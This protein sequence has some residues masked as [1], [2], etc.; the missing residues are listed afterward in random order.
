[1]CLILLEVFITTRY[2]KKDD[3]EERQQQ[4]RATLMDTQR[5]Q[6]ELESFVDIKRRNNEPIH[7]E[8]IKHYQQLVARAF[9]SQGNWRRIYWVEGTA[10]IP[11]GPC[12]TFALS[13]GRVFRNKVKIKRFNFEIIVDVK[14]L[15]QLLYDQFPIIFP[16]A[17][18]EAFVRSAESRTFGTMGS[19]DFS[20]KE[21][22]YD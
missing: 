2:T 15:W 20:S 21:N 8:E 10:K 18:E 3:E 11:L 5:A 7:I 19:F 14:D 22:L 16:S 13:I 4:I 12:H 1:M 9:L 17:L 6:Q